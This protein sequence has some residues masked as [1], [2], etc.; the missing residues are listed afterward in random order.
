MEKNVVKT[1]IVE[2]QQF[3]KEVTFSFLMRYR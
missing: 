3:V 2:Y 1:L